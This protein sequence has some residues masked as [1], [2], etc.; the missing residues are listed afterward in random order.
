MTTLTGTIVTPDGDPA[1]GVVV[2]QLAGEDGRALPTAFVGDETIVGASSTELDENGQYSIDIA[3]NADIIPAGTRWA[4]SHGTGR[5]AATIYLDV[6]TSGTVSEEDIVADPPGSIASAALTIHAGLSP[7]SGD[8]VHGAI[9]LDWSRDGWDAFTAVTMTADGDQVF[10]RTVEDGRG[11]ITGTVAGSGNRREVYLIN[12][13][14]DW[15]NSELES[16]IYSPAG[17]SGQWQQWHLH[18]VRERAPGEWEGIAIW[19]AV[20][21][22][23]FDLLNCRAVRFDGTTLLQSTGDVATRADRDWLDRT[24][25]LQSVSRFEAFGLWFANLHIAPR[26]ILGTLQAGDLI[27]VDAVSDSSFDYD[28]IAVNQVDHA[29]GVIQVIDPSS[30]TAVSRTAEAGT[31]RP[32]TDQKRWAPFRM[33][34]R[35]I[36]GTTD[37][38]VVEI[39]RSRA[40]EPLPDWGDARVLRQTILPNANVPELPIDAGAVALGGAHF[41]ENTGGS[42]GEVAARRV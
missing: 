10:D 15:A 9:S 5:T 26:S 16:V 14:E 20:V 27:D 39:R 40:E 32:V 23:G 37:E 35:V 31:V 3:G 22:G 17:P 30:T 36:G 13:T 11:V 41:Q 34:T 42:F 24:L 38:L 4:R 28:D 8:E 2:L 19:T 33:A 1:T 12:G 7:A 21:G 25:H 29:A 18:R 6:P